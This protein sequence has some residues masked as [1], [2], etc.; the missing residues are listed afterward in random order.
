MGRH[1]WKSWL[2]LI[3]GALITGSIQAEE[4]TVE[5][6]IGLKSLGFSETEIQQQVKTSGTV[7]QLTE[8]QTETLRKAAADFTG[9]VQAVTPEGPPRTSST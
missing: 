6:L 7:F 4:L 3:L 9:G 2:L 5:S 1:I 8:T